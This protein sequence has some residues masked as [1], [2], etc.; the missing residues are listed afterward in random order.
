MMIFGCTGPS[1]LPEV[2]L[3]AVTGPLFLRYGLLSVLVSLAVAPRLESVG[4]VVLLHGLCCS[5]VCG[6][7]PD[8]R[9]NPCP[10]HWQVNF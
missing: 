4:S 5:S 6:I 10:L 7:F 3:V 2:L 8:Q 9:S 1:L